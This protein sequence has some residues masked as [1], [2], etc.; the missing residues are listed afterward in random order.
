MK[1]FYNQVTLDERDG[2]ARVLI[3]GRPLKTPAKNDL[4][5]PPGAFADAVAGEWK[6]Q[7]DEID[8]GS[9][10][11]TRLANSAIDGVSAR[12]PEVRAHI[13]A[14]GETDLICHWAEAPQEL[15]KR[16]AEAWQPVLD[17]VEGH[18]GAAFLP[19]QGI[20]P[21]KQ[22]A[23][24][25]G[26]LADEIA[27]FDDFALA[28][29]H[30]V[31]TLTGSVLLALAVT[32]GAIEPD[33]AWSAAHVDEAFQAEQWGEDEEAKRRQAARRAAY[34]DAVRALQLL[35]NPT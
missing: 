10:P 1:R 28:A 35:R 24:A 15:V 16:Q 14:Y 2:K 9:M 7:G 25:L 29:L 26:T 13:C 30:E 21:E 34:D 19:V 11:L 3:D 17:W 33:A 23:H 32:R 4:V 5:L 20:V 6:A 12:A 8:P 18:L 31:T 27:T 22:D